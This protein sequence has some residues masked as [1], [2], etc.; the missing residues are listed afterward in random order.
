MFVEV[1]VGELEGVTYAACHA[2]GAAGTEKDAEGGVRG[3]TRLTGRRTGVLEVAGGVQ[4]LA[5]GGAGGE[6]GVL[7]RP[8]GGAEAF[9]RLP[10]GALDGLVA[11]ALDGLGGLPGGA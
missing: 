5:E 10:G 1:G 4:E 9:D 2:A 6:T 8:D 3:R 7:G 11:E